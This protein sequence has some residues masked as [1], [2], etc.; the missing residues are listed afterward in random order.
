MGTEIQEFAASLRELKERS[1]LSYGALARKLHMSTSTIHRYCNGEAVPHDYAPVERFARV[2][3]AGADELVVLHRQWILA[4]E[5]RRR[6]K[7]EG[8]A[9]VAASAA[10]PVAASGEAPGAASGEGPVAA[11]GEAP[12]SDSGK[13]PDPEAKAGP[14]V[15]DP[16]AGPPAPEAEA[17]PPAPE[18]EVVP[19]VPGPGPLGP[20]PESVRDSAPESLAPEPALGALAENEITREAAE[21]AASRW[22]RA[23]GRT[24]VL[25]AV[26]AVVALT[27]PTAV[28][29]GEL[30]NAGSDTAAERPK[31]AASG[32]G[33]AADAVSE[34]PGSPSPSVS[35]SKR[36]SPS[37]ST[38]SASASTTPS[39]SSS[40]GSGA[41][42]GKPRS[43]PGRPPTAAITSYNWDGPCGQFYL[44]DQ[45]ADS[46]PPPPD[47]PKTSRGWAKVLGGVDG[48]TMMLEITVQGTSEQAV[49]LN[50]LRVRVL[51]QRA[52]LQH[53]AFS[54]GEGCGST[55]EPQSFK[56][57]L[58]DSR[59]TLVP[60]A[61]MQADGPIPAKNFPFRVSASDVE[62]FDIEAHVEGHDVSWVLELDWS[63]GGRT[64]TLEIDDGGK[65]FR[66]SSIAGRPTYYYR[67]D[68][69][70]WEKR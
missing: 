1:G 31:G 24:R 66:T 19:P 28:V 37:A 15:P 5:A 43:E 14:L 3:R 50:A 62:V 32:D 35:A 55:I 68:T 20:G 45:D 61:G 44:V 18:P 65:P 9:P 7:S 40:A 29:V 58:D 69:T 26:A 56:V 54:M 13:A 64:G 57:D 17:G 51:S 8:G 70:V 6:G 48:G 60:V 52:P 42:A 49:V 2:C 23:S 59:P 4:D 67:W 33:K 53:S 63:S 41:G 22:R 12:A 27:V 11:S 38:G 25:L 30:R 46:V 21:P 34:G 16:A 36:P 10:A 47:N 39:G